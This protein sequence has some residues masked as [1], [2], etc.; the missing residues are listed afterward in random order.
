[1]CSSPNKVLER[2]DPSASAPPLQPDP[3][4]R[5]EKERTRSAGSVIFFSA[6]LRGANSSH[7]QLG[8]NP[9]PA[10]LQLYLFPVPVPALQHTTLKEVRQQGHRWIQLKVTYEEIDVRSR[11]IP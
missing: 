11:S 2:P 5:G 10:C 7:P 3:F 8:S 9:P 1:M 4:V 6:C